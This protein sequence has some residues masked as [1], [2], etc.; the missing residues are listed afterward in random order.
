MT[1]PDDGQKWQKGLTEAH[2]KVYR[3]GE[4]LVLE[5][6]VPELCAARHHHM[7]P[8]A[9]EMQ[10]LDMQRQFKVDEIGLY[11]DI[12]QVKKACSVCHACNPDNQKI[13]GEAPWT[14]IPDHPTES[15]AMDVFSILDVHIR[16]EVLNCVDLCVDQHSG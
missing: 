13:K 5:F 1:D 8:P 11:N 14:P 6:G 7:M 15:V 12:K 2:G 10:A 9:V 3:N 4:L 16:R